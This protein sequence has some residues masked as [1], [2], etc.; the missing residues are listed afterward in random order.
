MNISLLHIA[1][2]MLGLV[3]IVFVGWI[4][5][6]RDMH[7]WDDWYA[8]MTWQSRFRERDEPE[9]E[10]HVSDLTSKKSKTSTSPSISCDY[11][12]CEV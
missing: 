11:V 9:I 7:R 8:L 4:K 5:C 3:A 6:Q 12:V 1:L 2:F 10:K